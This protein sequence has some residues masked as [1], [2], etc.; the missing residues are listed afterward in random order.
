MGCVLQAGLGQSPAKQAALQAGISDHVPATTVNKVCASGL[1]A[2]MLGAQSI[3]IGDND[4]VIAG[5]MESMS[6]VP[7]YLPSG[8]DGQKFG[9]VTLVDGW[10]YDGLT[11]AF[12]NEHMACAG[13]PAPK[14]TAL[15]G[16][17]RTPLPSRATRAAPKPGAKGCSTPRSSPSR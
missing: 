12:S 10:L 3:E 16:R 14:P 6:R 2:V 15:R 17:N 5:G 9:H 8:R 7:H 13:K 1:K 4:I 11:D